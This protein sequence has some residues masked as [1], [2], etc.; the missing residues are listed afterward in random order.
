MAVEWIS[1]HDRQALNE[2]AEQLQIYGGMDNTMKKS[3]RNV[4]VG[5]I[6]VFGLIIVL[7]LSACSNKGNA[8]AKSLY[9]QGLEIVRLMSEMTQTE[10]YVDVYTGNGEVKAVIQSISAGDYSSPKA[11]YAISVAD[12]DLAAMV[13]L[14]RLDN[15]SDELKKFLLQRSRSALMTQI[16]SMSGVENLAATSVCTAG[17]SFVSENAAE[18]AIYLYTYENARPIAVTFTIGE[19]QAVSATGMFVMYDGFTCG[20]VAEIESFFSDIT[21]NVSEVLPEK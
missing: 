17:K 2:W 4:L 15:V 1:G 12:D 11:V 16:N 3:V 19:N 14:N 10:G 9:E 8:E 20:S 13:E 5:L 7:S 6:I 18:D 21:V